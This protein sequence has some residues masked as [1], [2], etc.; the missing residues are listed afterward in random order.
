MAT[1]ETLQARADAVAE[2]LYRTY[3]DDSLKELMSYGEKYTMLNPSDEL[4]P[5]MNIALRK[6]AERREHLRQQTR[7]GDR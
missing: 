2:M 6:I 7:G 1:E 5:Y 4:A 3:D